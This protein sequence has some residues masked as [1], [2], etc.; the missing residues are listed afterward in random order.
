MEV[1][2]S[3]VIASHISDIQTGVLTA[4]DVNNRLN[5]IKWLII[6]H[7]DLNAEINADAEWEAFTK[8]RF[9]KK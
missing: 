6:G 4:N 8:T 9:Y 5:F 1:K 7:T 2:L 3:I